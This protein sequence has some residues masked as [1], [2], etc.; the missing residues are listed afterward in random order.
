MSHM[1]PISTTISLTLKNYPGVAQRIFCFL[2]SFIT[3]STLFCLDFAVPLILCP[4]VQHCYFLI[5]ICQNRY[6]F[7]SE[8]LISTLKTS[9]S[10]LYNKDLMSC[11]S[12]EFCLFPLFLQ[13]ASFQISC[14]A[15]VLFISYSFLFSALEPSARPGR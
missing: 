1:V 3:C 8:F 12:M 14:L 15:M 6:F 4:R 5:L 7:M 11:F 2:V 9:K 13:S 10:L